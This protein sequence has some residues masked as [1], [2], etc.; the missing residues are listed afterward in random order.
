MLRR[1]SILIGI[2]IL[3]ATGCATTQSGS[4]AGRYG[5]DSRQSLNSWVDNELIPYMVKQLGQHPKFKGS[6]FLIVDMDG[7]NVQPKIDD[8]T[9]HIRSK[10]IDA[11]LEEPGINLV[12]RPAVR[13]WKHN[14]S[15]KEIKCGEFRD[16]EYYIGIDA[17]MTRVGKKLHLQVRALNME[18]GSWESGFGRSWRGRPSKEEREALKRSHVD[19]YL[20]GLRPLPFTGEQPDLLAS[21]LAQN[22][23]CL[24]KHQATENLNLRIKRPSADLPGFFQTTVALVDNYLD[25]FNEVRVVGE[26]AKSNCIVST[27]VHHLS[28]D[29]Y[30]VWVSARSNANETSWSGT[31]TEAYV[32]VS[33]LKREQVQTSQEDRPHRAQEFVPERP[34]TE[35]E[36]ETAP[37]PEKRQS[38]LIASFKLFT[39]VSQAFCG[40]DRPWIVGSREL[41]Q[42][43]HLKTGGCVGLELSLRHPARV[44]LVNQNGQGELTRLLPTA[45]EELQQIHNRLNMQ[46]TL[47]YPP[48]GQGSIQA[49]ELQGEP[50]QERIYAL[51]VSDS[52]LADK[53]ENRLDALQGLCSSGESR[54][55]YPGA[56]HGSEQ[57]WKKFLMDLKEQGKARFDWQVKRFWH[58]KSK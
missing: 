21:Y 27:E 36:T 37:A 55:A 14:R 34:E 2:L 22:L 52:A 29:L 9:E 48:H 19:E 28:K 8:L 38:P 50:G 30:Q 39:P 56:N 42:G 20:R 1:W 6:P 23:S 7:D 11:M 26:G 10:L 25:K 43:E 47:R 41:K 51:A 53:I 17:E 13:P 31:G 45:C 35:I 40:T 54:I 4:G 15:L 58:D 32:R 44:F 18:Q 5:A 24:F 12:W 33:K 57:D 49:L 3:L 16:I 46:E